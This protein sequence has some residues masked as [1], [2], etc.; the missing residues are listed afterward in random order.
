MR[1]KNNYWHT[2]EGRKRMGVGPGG[3]GEDRGTET[4]QT[5][6]NHTESFYL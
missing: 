3:G 6:N 4:T 1:S 2:A 5:K